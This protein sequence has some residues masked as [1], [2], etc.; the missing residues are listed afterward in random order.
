MLGRRHVLPSVPTTLT[1]LMVEGTFPTGT[2]LVTVHHPISTDDGDLAKALYGSFLPVPNASIFPLPTAEE[3]APEKQ[4]G[5]LITVKGKV[6]LNEGRKRIR[7]S[8]TS[9]GDRP[10]QVFT[11]LRAYQKQFGAGELTDMFRS[12]A[13]TTLS[14]RTLS[15]NSIASK[16][17]DTASTSQLGH[18]FDLSLEIPRP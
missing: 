9:K 18:P 14:K 4:P 8:V 1:E 5:A 11:P 3:Y 15:S 16:H 7:L 17:T 6:V 12:G 2:Y 13:I 10:V